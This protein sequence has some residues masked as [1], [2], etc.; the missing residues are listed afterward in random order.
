ME[1]YLAAPLLLRVP[2][3]IHQ[4]LPHSDPMNAANVL[5]QAMVDAGPGTEQDRS[6]TLQGVV[7]KGQAPPVH[8][9]YDTLHTW[10]F[11]MSR[12]TALGVH[13]PAPWGAAQCAHPLRHQDDGG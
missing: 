5:F 12:L 13:P 2:T 7:A 9:I 11:D 10:R 3:H 6:N 8:L 1:R 4:T